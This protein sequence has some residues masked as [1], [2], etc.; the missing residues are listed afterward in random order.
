MTEF[1]E[2][3]IIYENYNFT[4]YVKNNT[5]TDIIVFDKMYPNEYF[6]I[7]YNTDYYVNNKFYK[8]VINALNNKENC[9]IKINKHSDFLDCILSYK[10]DFI[11]F[12]QHFKLIKKNLNLNDILHTIKK[13]NDK[14]D[15]LYLSCCRLKNNEL[16]FAIK[17]LQQTTEQLYND[18]LKLD[19]LV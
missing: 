11:D 12:V 15:Y 14:I 1:V 5:I 6:E 2:E 18:Y 7:E 4:L 13:L 9:S 17:Q 16:I 19:K 8:L 10:N 3:T